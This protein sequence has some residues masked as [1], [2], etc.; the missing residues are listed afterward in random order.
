MV[1]KDEIEKSVCRRCSA[2]GAYKYK[3]TTFCFT[4]NRRIVYRRTPGAMG[5][6]WEHLTQKMTKKGSKWMI[7]QANNPDVEVELT[8]AIFTAIH[9]IHTDSDSE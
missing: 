7:K 9:S 6:V 8:D 4:C 1:N 5:N 2:E 3:N